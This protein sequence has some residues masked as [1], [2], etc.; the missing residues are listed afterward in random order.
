MIYTFVILLLLISNF[1]FIKK[2]YEFGKTILE[3]Q[4][5]LEDSL[6]VLNARTESITKVLEIPLF[7]D[8]PEIR[9]VHEDITVVRDSIRGVAETFSIIE[10][11]VED[12][13]NDD[14]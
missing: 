3:I 2:S 9:R 8:S 14:R 13:E 10:N 6:N 7:F 12:I 4:D 5:A 1:Y 11:E